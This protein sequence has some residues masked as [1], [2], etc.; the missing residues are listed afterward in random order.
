ME[1]TIFKIV[2]KRIVEDSIV[3]TKEEFIDI[4]NTKKPFQIFCP[5][6]STTKS[7]WVIVAYPGDNQVTYYATSWADKTPVM[8]SM[9][10]IY[11]SWRIQGLVDYYFNF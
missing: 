10:N 3:I 11:T 4:L 5:D 9:S 2:T 8:D 1:K 6:Y 7:L